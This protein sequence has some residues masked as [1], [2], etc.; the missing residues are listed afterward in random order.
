MSKVSKNARKL[1]YSL[2]ETPS[3]PTVAAPEPV[4]T[5]KPDPSSCPKCGRKGLLST[6][7][8]EYGGRDRYCAACAGEE[9]GE[10]YR[11]ASGDGVPF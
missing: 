2:F 1:N 3:L 7:A 5:A 10:P 9:A 6:R 11:W 4:E 8:M